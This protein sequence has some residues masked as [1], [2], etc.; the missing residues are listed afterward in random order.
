MVEAG[1][2]QFF[3]LTRKGELYGWGVVDLLGVGV[4]KLVKKN[5][6]LEI[7]ILFGTPAAVSSGAVSCI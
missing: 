2:E 7:M 1:D 5:D 3:A 6:T 4:L